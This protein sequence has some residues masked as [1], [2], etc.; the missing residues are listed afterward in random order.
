MTRRIRRHRDFEILLQIKSD[1]FL[2]TP[3]EDQRNW[4]LNRAIREMADD[5][6]ALDSRAGRFVRGADPTPLG[7]RRRAHLAPEELMEDWQIPVMRAMARAV[8]DTRGDILEVGF[9]RGVAASMIQEAEVRSHTIIECNS[10]V[11]DDLRAW[12]AGYPGRDIRLV[13]GRWQDVTADLEMYDGILFHAY[14]LD[15]Q[16]F[17][18]QVVGSVTF[19]AHFF[20]TAAARLRPGGRFTYLTNEA[21]SLSRSHQRLLFGSFSSFTLSQ[22]TDLAV[23][24]DTRDAHWMNEMVVIKAVR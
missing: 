2:R 23:P 7:D 5:L 13:E 19:A 8:T 22:V 14:P 3:R 24:D 20:P 18:E 15:E 11:I 4:V 16:D 9:G 17:A 1:D 21:D 10:H 12:R 6:T